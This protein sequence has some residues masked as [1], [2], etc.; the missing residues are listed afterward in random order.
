LQEASARKRKPRLP[1][2]Q[3]N[4]ISVASAGQNRPR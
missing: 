4:I 3:T 1:H 2:N